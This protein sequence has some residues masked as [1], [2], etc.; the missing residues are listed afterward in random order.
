MACG[1]RSNDGMGA[2]MGGATA[3]NRSGEEGDGRGCS[4]GES[5][6][7]R[8]RIEAAT[9]QRE[10]TPMGTAASSS[11]G[12]PGGEGDGNGDEKQPGGVVFDLER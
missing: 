1:S 11:A 3:A 4:P 7:L 6:R 9:N 12:Q 5:E 10:K 2:A 8:R